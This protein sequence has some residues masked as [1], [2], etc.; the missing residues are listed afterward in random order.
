VVGRVQQYGLDTDD[1]IA[2]YRTHAQRP[3]R[4]LYV[5]VH[6]TADPSALRGPASG[7]VHDLDPDVPVHRLT[8]M[9]ARVERAVAGRRFAMTALVLFAVVALVLAAWAPTVSS[10]TW[11]VRGHGTWGSGSPSGPRLVP[12]SRW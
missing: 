5:A 9:P 11:S 2:I 1:R 6:T 4:V 12:F 7:A 8:P 3:A 10:L